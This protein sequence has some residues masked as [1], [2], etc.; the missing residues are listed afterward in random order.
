VVPEAELKVSL[1]VVGPSRLIGFGSANP[2]AVGSFQTSDAKTFRGRALAILRG[3]GG[4]GAV[5]LEARAEGLQGG[6]ATIRLV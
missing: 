1:T 3:T 2:L 5:R 6:T 4:K